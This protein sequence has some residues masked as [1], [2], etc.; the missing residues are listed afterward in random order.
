M[1]RPLSNWDGPIMNFA[2]TMRRYATTKMRFD[3]SRGIL[4]ISSKLGDCGGI[5]DPYGSVWIW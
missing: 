2:F 4:S 5:G 1:R 3:L